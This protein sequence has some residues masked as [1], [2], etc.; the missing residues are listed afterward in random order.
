MEDKKPL[1]NYIL[2]ETYII[3]SDKGEKDVVCFEL[4]ENY[5]FMCPYCEKEEEVEFHLDKT[6]VFPRYPYSDDET[7][8]IKSIIKDRE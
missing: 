1:I 8:P 7:Y 6:L 4:T 2:G 5:A 3:Q